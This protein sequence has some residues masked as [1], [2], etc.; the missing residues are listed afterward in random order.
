MSKWRRVT[1]NTMVRP[2]NGT[3]CSHKKRMRKI[4]EIIRID[5]QVVLLIKI[6]VQKSIFTMLLFHVRKKGN[7][8]KYTCQLTCAK[9]IQE[10]KT[11]N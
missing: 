11:K 2:H 1:E 6:K 9:G 10:T 3:L 7:I 5:I 8:G 4:S